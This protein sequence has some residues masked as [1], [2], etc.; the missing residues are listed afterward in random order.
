MICQSIICL[1]RIEIQHTCINKSISYCCISSLMRILYI[2]HYLWP[3][4][5]L[6]EKFVELP[7]FLGSMPPQANTCIEHTW[8]AYKYC[9]FNPPSGRW[10]EQNVGKL[11][12]SRETALSLLVAHNTP[13]EKLESD[14]PQQH[15]FSQFE[16][17]YFWTSIVNILI[18]T[19]GC[20]LKVVCVHT[21]LVSF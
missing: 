3:S 9:H 1:Q 21:I 12:L 17:I 16:S 2:Y 6:F 10:K 20:K 8:I 7:Y 5:I 14:V 11:S 18:T 13:S 19:L 15:S 4:D